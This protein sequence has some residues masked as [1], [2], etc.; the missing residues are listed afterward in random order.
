VVGVRD[1]IYGEDIKAFVVLKPGEMATA[2]EIMDCC[3]ERLKGFKTPRE[4]AFIDA[5]P[6]SLVGK[7]L[8][9]ELRTRV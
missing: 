6:K 5:L 1:D 3:S 8:R 4:V 9:R 2:E 7:V